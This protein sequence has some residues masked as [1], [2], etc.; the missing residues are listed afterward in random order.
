M[1]RCVLYLSCRLLSKITNESNIGGCKKLHHMN[2]ASKKTTKK[3]SNPPPRR[4]ARKKQQPFLSNAPRTPG[5]IITTLGRKRANPVALSHYVKCR[6]DP[7][8]SPGGAGIPD[9]QNSNF[10]V[11]D[12]FSVNNFSATVAG[13]SIV[14]Q[15]TNT[16]PSCAMIASL[17]PMTVDGLTVAASTSLQPVAATA[18]TSWYPI[19][20]PSSYIG[21]GAADTVFADPYQ[22]ST[23]RMVSCGFRL[24]YTGP[25][26]TC[27]GTIRI[28]P[29]N[30]GWTIGAPSTAGATVENV[31]RAGA[32]GANLVIGTP[33]IVAD[34]NI[35]S[36]AMT[37]STMTL[38]PE[39]GLYVLPTHKANNFKN[40]PTYVVP[41]VPVA[42]VNQAGVAVNQNNLWRDAGGSPITLGIV[43]F[44]NDWACYQIALS[45]LNADASFTLE[46]V[47]CVEY[48][49]AVTSPWF[50]NSIGSSPNKPGEIAQG[51]AAAEK[52]QMA[53]A[54][55]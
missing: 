32:P 18:S 8:H 51:Q 35:N 36:T 17:S 20:I 21:L 2:Q 55:K 26:Q 40:Q 37:R 3:K 19:C 43:W 29:N 39:Q 28:T 23:A 46:A 45:G 33:I 30:I 5:T 7:F 31:T 41:Y 24:I 47:V 27:A 6:I 11:A 25:A 52:V 14:I 38:R 48:N 34:I 13:Q 10:V 50:P 9:G 12:T 15:T 22:S 42:N 53:P 4:T 16:L 49:P 54:T 44:D 1:W